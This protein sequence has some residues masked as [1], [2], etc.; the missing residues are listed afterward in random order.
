MLKIR[1]GLRIEFTLMVVLSLNFARKIVMLSCGFN[2]TIV[3]S[4][5]L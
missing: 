4:I 5:E 3:A 2:N 1:V